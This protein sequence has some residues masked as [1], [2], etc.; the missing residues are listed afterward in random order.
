MWVGPGQTTKV[1]PPGIAGLPAAVWGGLAGGLF[2]SVG[3]ARD[4]GDFGSHS[5]IWDIA[6]ALEIVHLRIQYKN[7]S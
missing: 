7:M 6:L 1:M 5:G 2:P 3:H 4:S